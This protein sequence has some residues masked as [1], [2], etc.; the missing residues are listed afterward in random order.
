MNINARTIGQAAAT[1]ARR[2]ATLLLLAWAVTAPTIV[3]LCSCETPWLQ[4]PETLAWRK[5]TVAETQTMIDNTGAQLAKVTEKAIGSTYTPAITA[6]TQ[7][8]ALI[9]AWTVRPPTEKTNTK[10]PKESNP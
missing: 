3:G 6:I 10:L 5:A 7:L 2:P 9:F 4:D 8:A 1:R